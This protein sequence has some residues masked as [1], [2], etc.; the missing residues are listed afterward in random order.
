M[1]VF[2]G[3]EGFSAIELDEA[4]EDIALDETFEIRSNLSILHD[5]DGIEDE[6]VEEQ[7]V[8]DTMSERSM[9]AFNE[10][11]QQ[12][13]SD[14]SSTSHIFSDSHPDYERIDPDLLVNNHQGSYAIQQILSQVVDLTQNLNNATI[15]ISIETQGLKLNFSNK[16]VHPEY[17][18]ITNI[19]GE[20]IEFVRAFRSSF[21]INIKQGYPSD[22][23]ELEETLRGFQRRKHNFRRG[24]RHHRWARVST[25]EIFV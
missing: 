6:V 21:R 10:P 1:F 3:P 4:T 9:E 16:K 5:Q 7:S 2:R 18:T 23:K 13:Q 11:L 14:T 22:E 25:N 8:S 24:R 17:Q 20:N 19:P 15:S 12:I